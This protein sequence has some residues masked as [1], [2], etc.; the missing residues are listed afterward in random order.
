MAFPIPNFFWIIIVSILFQLVS[1]NSFAQK[2]ANIWYFGHYA[3]LDFSGGSPTVLNNGQIFTEEGVAAICSSSGSLL[4]YT[5]GITVWNKQHQIMPNGNG[6][7]GDVSSTQSAI[8]VPKIGDASRYYV[9]TVDQLGGAKGLNYSIINMELDNG[10]GDV[11]IKNIQLKIPVT[12]KI[13]A[14]KH[15]NGRDIWVIAHGWN[16]NAY[17]AYL[18]TGS[19]INT[20]PVTSNTGRVVTG[21]VDCNIGYLKASPNGKK[22]AAAHNL[23][24][25]DVL[26]F[27]NVTGIVSNPQSLFLPAENYSSPYGVEFSPDSKLLYSTVFYFDVSALQTKNIVL[28]YDISQPT[29]AGIITSKKI[30]YSNNWTYQTFGALQMAPDGKMYMSHLLTQPT[31]SVINSPDS[32][33]VACNF[34]LDQIQFSGSN[35]RGRFGLPTFIQSYWQPG[36]TFSNACTGQSINFYYTKPSNVTSVKW[37]FG[38][39]ASGMNNISISDSPV[40]LFSAPGLFNVKL[41]RYS[42]CGSDTVNKVIQA[43]KLNVNLGNDTILCG[44]SNFVLI[45]TK[46]SGNLFLW[47]DGSSNS[48]YQANQSGLYWVEVKDLV[49][50]CSARDS[51][52]LYFNPYPDFSLGNDTSICKGASVTLKANIIPATFLWNTGK[53]TNTETINTSGNYWLEISQNGCMKRDSINVLVK[54]LPFVQLGNDTILCSGE[55]LTLNATNS[56]ATYLWQDGSK[57]PIF[58]V[59]NPGAYSVKVLTNGCDTTGR[60]NVAYTSKPS[61]SLGNDTILCI[62]DHLLL[63]AFYPQ[64]NFLWNDGSTQP[65]YTITKPGVYSVNVSN[66]CGTTPSSINITYEN[67]AC[68]FYV[69]TAFTPNSD[70]INDVFKPG[71]QCLFDNYKL[72]IF[73]RWGQLVFIS[74]N[75]ANGWDGS[76]KKE[77]QPTG[78]YVWLMNYKDL[79]TGKSQEQKGMVM[80]IH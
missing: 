71:I 28:Q 42:G 55:M 38:D 60:I 25:L 57:Q 65:Q 10:N 3:G 54:P 18:V 76:W 26:D 13:T 52:N 45:P 34:V 12:E 67:C 46:S 16:S 2:E 70:G 64:S 56:N 68:K 22:L 7:F 47:Q 31:L 32:I 27:D 78:S 49:T 69:P 41:V 33:G 11:E 8:V 21:P 51:I 75:P 14:V 30:I 17:Y 23:L 15:C 62:K 5:D 44:S 1:F 36:F 20:V 66:I 4:F 19:G 50:G 29:L 77:P 59:N 72:K 43:G 39:V 73:N 37:D 24:D 53:T 61:I 35:Q 74:Q 58:I 79:L 63:N 48:T 80:L 6:L 40:H 9:F